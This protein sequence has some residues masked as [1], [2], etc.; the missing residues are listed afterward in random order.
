MHQDQAPPYFSL[1]QRKQILLERWHQVEEDLENQKKLTPPRSRRGAICRYFLF[2]LGMMGIAYYFLH[3]NS[4][5]RGYKTPPTMKQ[6][7]GNAPDSSHAGSSIA[8]GSPITTTPW[9]QDTEIKSFINFRPGS[10]SLDRDRA[11]LQPDPTERKALPVLFAI[12]VGSESKTI[13]S[14]LLSHFYRAGCTIVLFHYDD[15][16]WTSVPFYKE[17]IT[18]RASGQ[19]K[20]WFAKRFL[21]P[22]VVSSYDYIFLWDEDVIADPP[23]EPS[24]FIQTMRDYHIDIAQPSFNP[25]D[26]MH[27][28]K[29]NSSS[30]RVLDAAVGR[31]TNFVEMTFP[32]FSVATWKSC[33]WIALPYDAIPQFG[34][35]LAWYPLCAGVGRCRFAV[36]NMFQLNPEIKSHLPSEAQTLRDT[37]Y[38]EFIVGQ[39][40]PNLHTEV[41]TTPIIPLSQLHQQQLLCTYLKI[42]GYTNK[43]DI[44]EIV[45]GDNSTTGCLR[46][47]TWP[48][49]SV[50][51]FPP[52]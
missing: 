4:S 50:P 47:P 48:T 42:H 23:W 39:C 6:L 49:T 41:A 27:E 19:T 51:W 8:H 43:V 38:K 32:V 35:D 30:T 5:E 44:R 14:P 24:A 52:T 10:G 28:A 40:D 46:L 20:Y 13:V 18:V 21:T 22:D 33:I 34:M 25:G 11:Q 17:Y 29:L 7:V 12:T 1:F 45:K 3:R 26:V 2:T 9:L 36:L 15:S 31:W 37:H 16:D